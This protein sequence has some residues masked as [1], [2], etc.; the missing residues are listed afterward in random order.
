[1]N[2]QSVHDLLSG[3]EKVTLAM[4]EITAVKKG[5]QVLEQ[6]VSRQPDFDVEAVLEQQRTLLSGKLSSKER[7]KAVAPEYVRAAMLARFCTFLWGNS[8]VHFDVVLQL[9]HFLNKGIT[10]FMPLEVANG[11]ERLRLVDMAAALTGKGMVWY[12]GSWCAASEAMAAEGIP[13]LVLRLRDGFALTCGCPL[14][15][16]AAMLLVEKIPSMISTAMM[17][18]LWAN[19][20]NGTVSD[21][22][23]GEAMSSNRQWGVQQMSAS[24]RH[25]AEGSRCL[26]HQETFAATERLSG[27]VCGDWLLTAPQQLGALYDSW[28]SSL[29]VITNAYNSIDDAFASDEKGIFY[30]SGNGCGDALLLEME[31]LVLLARRLCSMLRHQTVFFDAMLSMPESWRKEIKRICALWPEA[32]NEPQGET[33]P[34]FQCET[35]VELPSSEIGEGMSVILR[36]EWN[37]KRA[38]KHLAMEAMVLARATVILQKQPLLASQTAA[39]SE[40]VSPFLE[41]E[42]AV[43]LPE[44]VKCLQQQEWQLM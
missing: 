29:N 17:L 15:K 22:V 6:W 16:G 14:E 7:G 26:R 23:S 2:V 42:P 41:N 4:Q 28:E 1:M 25:A 10:P 37:L 18:S 32:E 39:L 12:K 24:L 5:Y 9:M 27:E 21:F 20:L 36:T 38:W 3:R 34:D 8:G 31:K 44:V 43:V 13:P 33:E 11:D 40:A 30:I 35:D 19:E